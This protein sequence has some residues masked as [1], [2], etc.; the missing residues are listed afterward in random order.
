MCQLDGTAAFTKGLTTT[1][2]D[3]GYSFTGTLSSCN[4]SP[5]QPAPSGGTVTAGRQITVG[6]VTYQEPTPTG[7]GSCSSSTTSGLAIVQ[8]NG[9]GLTIVNYTTSG[10]LAA[11]TLQGSVVDSVTLPIVNPVVGGPTTGTL[12]TDTYKGY[13]SAGG[14]VFEPPDPT[15]CNTA[16]GVT[17]AGI[18]GQLGLGTS[19]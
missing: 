11:V 14:L 9:G 12:T 1:A 7:N 2:Q 18:Q 13:G 5:S 3:F 19:S 8:W 6:G 17:T 4:A 10:A 16:A 15:A